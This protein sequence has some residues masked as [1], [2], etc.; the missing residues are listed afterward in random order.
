MMHLS[1]T[2]PWLKIII[3]LIVAA[4]SAW[5]GSSLGNIPGFDAFDELLLQNVRNGFV[6][7]D[8]IAGDARFAAFVNELA[9]S[10]ASVLD[11]PDGGM[12]FYLNAYNALAIQGIL[13]GGSPE[14]RRSRARFFKKTTYV[15]LGE[16]ITLE[17]LERERIMSMGDPRIHFAIVCASMSCPRLSSRA[18]RPEE[19]N[20]QLHEAARR[21]VNDPTRNR[22]D[23]DRRIAFVSKIFE[24]YADDFANAGGSV[25][26]YLARFV[27]DAEVQEALRAEEFELR[28]VEYD[29]SLNGYISGRR[30]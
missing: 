17:E 29:W 6:D 23:L 28:H 14:K 19:I 11:G 3:A 20:T 4:A 26:R 18:Y 16:P 22:F 10:P 25:Q 15:L 9:D 30:N 5:P 13:D 7:Y 2:R 24:W 8:S 27:E 12:A 1:P 21:F